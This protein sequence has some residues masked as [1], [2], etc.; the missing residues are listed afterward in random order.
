V[1]YNE[2]EKV[3]DIPMRQ[4]RVLVIDD[5]IEV[6]RRLPGRIIPSKRTFE[7]KIWNVDLSSVHVEIERNGEGVYEFKNSTIMDLGQK[8]SVRPDLILADYGYV[9]RTVLNYWAERASGGYSVTADDLTGQLLTPVDLV[10]SVED[11]IANGNVDS[12]L[13]NSL[14]GNLL[15]FDGR[16]IIYTMTSKAFIAALGEVESRRSRVVPAF[17]R[18]EIGAIDTNLELYNREEFA[19]RKHE[20][21][22]YAHL[23]TGLINQAIQTTM[24]EAMLQEARNL[25]YLRFGRSVA[26]VGAIVAIG[27]GF[28]AV[29][30]FIG[31]RIAQLLQSG[32]YGSAAL[33]GAFAIVVVFIVGM[34]LPLAFGRVMSGLLGRNA[35]HSLEE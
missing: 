34:L 26:A 25:R 18:A 3:G 10:S 29:A 8:L 32:E 12:A 31:N 28:A 20:P 14:R 22:F 11:F 13:I 15:E 16:F 9:D 7:G 6:L 1:L 5:D 35:G 4:Y 19:S 30:E 33:V 27:S 23:V 17:P 21:D 2:G 24:L